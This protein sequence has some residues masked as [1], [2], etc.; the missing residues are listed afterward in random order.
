MRISLRF[1]KQTEQIIWVLLAILFAYISLVPFYYFQSQ[2]LDGPPMFSL[3]KYLPFFLAGSACCLCCF[4]IVKYS[5]PVLRTPIDRLLGLYLAVAL[6]S[7]LG[8]NY[9]LTG[10]SK[11]GYYNVTGGV[12]CLLVVQYCTSWEVIRRAAFFI[13]LVG[14]CA[15]SYT[16]FYPFVEQEPFWDA[17]QRMY[18]PY[19]TSHRAMGPFG[20]TVA[21][22]TYAMLLLPLAVWIFSVLQRVWFKIAWGIVCALFVPVI[23]LTQTRGTQ[24]AT[25]LCCLLM[26]PWLKKLG[27]ALARNTRGKLYGGLVIIAIVAL[28]AFFS[29][30]AKVDS[31]LQEVQQRWSEILQPQTVTIRGDRKVY[32]YGSLLEYTERFRIAQY[33]TVG[34]ILAEHPLLGVGFGTFT[35]EFERYRYSENYMVRE[36]P[37]HTTE[38]MYLMF[39]AET[40]ILGLI[41]RLI[42]MVAIFFVVLRAWL[43]AVDGAG[44]DLLWAYL[45]GYISLAVNMLTWDILNE[46]TMRMTYWL[47]TGLALGLVRC[48]EGLGVSVVEAADDAV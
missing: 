5:K 2:S 28:G 35:R 45:V 36:F 16:V 42:L 19:H 37:E 18:S 13:A 46:P 6:L 3:V 30:N 8:A 32:E 9:A 34:N 7:L 11:W 23:L 38:N 29:R 47:W 40:G 48:G 25:L 39:L 27:P 14:G 44:K 15:V 12:L 20:H 4:D 22:A 10:L 33:Y 26:V 17:V 41:S 31:V 1:Y 24:V 43:R 21:T